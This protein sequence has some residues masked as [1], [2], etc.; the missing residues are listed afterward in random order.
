MERYVFIFT[1]DDPIHREKDGMEVVPSVL[2]E[3]ANIDSAVALLAMYGAQRGRS[4]DI[5]DYHADIDVGTID[6]VCPEALSEPH[7]GLV[8]SLCSALAAY[9]V[10]P[11]KAAFIETVGK[12]LGESAEPRRSPTKAELLAELQGLLAKLTDDGYLDELAAGYSHPDTV[13]AFC[14]AVDAMAKAGE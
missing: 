14:D 13:N 6:V 3:A 11:D 12:L 4:N 7:T 1:N 5:N 9:R 2:I 8:S 10:V